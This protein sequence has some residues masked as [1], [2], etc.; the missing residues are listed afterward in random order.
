MK[1][2]EE[3]LISGQLALSLK[4]CTNFSPFQKAMSMQEEKRKA[5]A[6]VT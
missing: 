1:K 3:I 2:G 4:N 5:V 6:K